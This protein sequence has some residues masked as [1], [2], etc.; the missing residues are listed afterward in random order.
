MVL[1]TL[2]GNN[3]K[4][5]AMVISIIYR[6]QNITRATTFVCRKLSESLATVSEG[7][8]TNRRSVKI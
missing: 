7:L 3:K 4:H 1:I 2:T 5:I 8:L 6:I